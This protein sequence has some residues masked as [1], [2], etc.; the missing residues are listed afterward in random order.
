MGLVKVRSYQPLGALHVE[1]I[2]ESGVLLVERS[3]AVL[4]DKV[5]EASPLVLPDGRPARAG[6]HQAGAVRVAGEFLQEVP[7]QRLL[8]VSQLLTVLVTPVTFLVRDAPG[9]AGHHGALVLVLLHRDVVQDA[10]HAAAGGPGVSLT[11]H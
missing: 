5:E 3:A 4:P 11:D 6:D 1:E 10:L 8:E 2:L 9:L 7:R